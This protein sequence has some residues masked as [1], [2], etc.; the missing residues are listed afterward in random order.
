MA[1][2]VYEEN[3]ERRKSLFVLSFSQVH[4][5]CWYVT[6]SISFG[7]KSK[8]MDLFTIGGASVKRH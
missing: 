7:K 4:E 8:K 2:Y 6:A 1:A 3:L 5:Q